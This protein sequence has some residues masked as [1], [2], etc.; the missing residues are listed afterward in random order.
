[1]ISKVTSWFLNI[2]NSRLSVKGGMLP[3]QWVGKYHASPSWRIVTVMCHLIAVEPETR[4]YSSSGNRQGHSSTRNSSLL[5][6]S[7]HN[8]NKILRKMEKQ[9]QNRVL[10]LGLHLN[11]I[12]WKML[13]VQGRYRDS[14][15]I[16]QWGSCRKWDKVYV[17]NSTCHPLLLCLHLA[18][19]T[20]PSSNHWLSLL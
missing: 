17:Y 18:P 9:K 4:E 3:S 10:T 11:H 8:W 20:S 19:I 2:G 12:P 5:H 16:F 13:K 15:W 1:M 6:P 7:A 14:H